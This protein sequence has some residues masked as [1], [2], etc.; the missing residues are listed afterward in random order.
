M[1]R[2]ALAMV[3]GI[4]AL[5]SGA[6]A[7]PRAGQGHPPPQN[8]SKAPGTILKGK[9][10]VSKEI[11]KVTL[12]KAQEADLPNG[13]HLIVLEDH[14]APLV[15][16]QLIVDGAGGYYDP[17]A[18]PGLAGFTAT[19]MRE[20]TESKTSEQISEQL[21]RLAAT[22][23]VG[24][25]ISSTFA[26]VTG[27][28]LSSNVDTVLALMADVLLHPSFPQ[29][30]IDRYKTRSRANLMA[31]RANPAFLANER[32][33]QMVYGVHPGARISPT[34][35][36]LDALTRA[37]LVDFHHAHYVPDHAV[38]AISG[39]MT[40]AQAKEKV[41]AALAAWQKS[42]AALVPP[43]DPRPLRRRCSSARSRSTGRVLTTK[44]SRSP[45]ACS[46]ARKGGSSS[47]CASRRGIPTVPAAG[48][49]RD[50]SGADGTPRPMCARRSP[51]PR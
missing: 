51:T 45:T 13:V 42:G 11:L 43:E 50:A 44:P 1:K 41:G 25:S 23:G 2:H 12:P 26:T 39:D 4:A 46:A 33:N 48:S 8:P 6:T 21:D 18:E 34:P 7:A 16:F 30:E 9:A 15:T 47:I 27:S 5:G 31:Q 40:I 24:A 28:G 22:V 17:A 49:L 20:G 19:L 29:T 10:P 37:A 32:L 35:A 14:R 38:M 3:I 36:S